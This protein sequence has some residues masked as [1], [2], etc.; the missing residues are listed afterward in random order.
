VDRPDHRGGRERRG[1]QAASTIYGGTETTSLRARV[2]FDQW[3]QALPAM[4]WWQAWLATPLGSPSHCSSAPALLT[5]TSA[6][7]AKGV[8][9]SGR[10]LNVPALFGRD[11]VP[12]QPAKRAALCGGGGSPE[13]QVI[14]LRG[15]DCPRSRDPSV[16][17]RESPPLA[18]AAQAEGGTSQSGVSVA[19]KSRCASGS[20]RR[21]RADVAAFDRPPGTV[22]HLEDVT[23]GADVVH[24]PTLVCST[25][26]PP[27]PSTETVTVHWLSF[28][29]DQVASSPSPRAGAQLETSTSRGSNTRRDAASATHEHNLGLTIR[30]ATLF[31]SPTRLLRQFSTSHDSS[32]MI[33]SPNAPEQRP[34]GAT[35][36]F[37]IRPSPVLPVRTE[38][39]SQRLRRQ[40]CL[41]SQERPQETPPQRPPPP[42]TRR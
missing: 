35:P 16:G 24:G 21:R 1:H 20:P 14:A 18:D 39:T 34:S 17:P 31:C 19:S 30:F 32:A 6:T 23:P 5:Q 2:Y 7:D 13:R 36:A 25:R 33:Q 26:S 22:L 9:R 42:R 3:D 37:P 12:E 11:A 27:Q 15:G 4:R 8:L 10:P 41:G 38:G 40:W 28:Q 29:H